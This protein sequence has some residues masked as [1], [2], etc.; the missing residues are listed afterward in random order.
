MNNLKYS[1]KFISDMI[2]G[3]NLT[4]SKER[5]LIL[6]ITAL[7]NMRINIGDFVRIDSTTYVVGFRGL[8]NVDGFTEEYEDFG[9]IYLE[10]E[11]E[12]VNAKHIKENF[13]FA[14]N[15]IHAEI[16]KLRGLYRKRVSPKDLSSEKYRDALEEKDKQLAKLEDEYK[17]N[18][19]TTDMLSKALLNQVRENT[20]LLVKGKTKK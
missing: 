5:E 8:V 12:K 4:P 9:Y 16:E 2:K 10:A 15:V 20:K 14:L 18:L 6:C 7:H 3:F 11:S 19:K 17:S 13:E 1:L